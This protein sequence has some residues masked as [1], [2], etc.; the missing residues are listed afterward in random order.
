MDSDLTFRNSFWRALALQSF[1]SFVFFLS[2]GMAYADDVEPCLPGQLHCTSL[3]CAGLE[4]NCAISQ[5]GPAYEYQ[6]EKDSEGNEVLTGNDVLACKKLTT[7][8]C[9]SAGV[10]LYTT[11]RKNDIVSIRHEGKTIWSS[12][13]LTK[14]INKL[15]VF[16][17]HHN[18]LR[19]NDDIK[20]WKNFVSI[21]HGENLDLFYLLAVSDAGEATPIFLRL[22]D[23]DSLGVSFYDKGPQITLGQNKDVFIQYCFDQGRWTSS[24]VHRA[25][26]NWNSLPD[27]NGGDPAGTLECGET[28]IVFFDGSQNQTCCPITY[29]CGDYPKTWTENF[30]THNRLYTQNCTRKNGPQEPTFTEIPKTIPDNP[31]G[32]PPSIIDQP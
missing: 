10:T 26:H 1:Y 4:Y 6:C 16:G 15:A 9:F 19:C 3:P 32:Q 2:F 21:R 8:T 29:L 22:Q 18:S 24:D 20:S 25:K 31:L 12:G 23:G 27:G 28:A 17:E 30:G 14:G 7:Q 5:T 11:G 13:V